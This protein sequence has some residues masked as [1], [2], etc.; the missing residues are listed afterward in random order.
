M[1]DTTPADDV[2]RLYGAP[3][4][5]YLQNDI[6]DVLERWIDD[7]MPP[8]DEPWPDRETA[9]CEVE[10]W[11]TTT[12][13]SLLPRYDWVLE[14]ILERVGDDAMF[15]EMYE[16]VE[17]RFERPAVFEAAKQFMATLAENLTGGGWRLADK[18]V[19]TH[20]FTFNEDRKPVLN[21]EVYEL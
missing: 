5:E 4:D 20:R 18:C 21:G 1:T 11:T 9:V 19:A 8:D 2:D 17:G 3:G 15:E 12:A 7:N 13:G 6:P 14:Q 16:H 10:E